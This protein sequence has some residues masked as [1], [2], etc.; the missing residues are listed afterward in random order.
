MEALSSLP[1]WVTDLEID[2]LLFSF[3][4]ASL[5]AG[6][7]VLR[8]AHQKRAM[9]LVLLAGAGDGEV[10]KR[11]TVEESTKRSVGRGAETGSGT[12]R[13]GH[14]LEVVHVLLLLHCG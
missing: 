12:L 4:E 5:E 1:S 2:G 6:F 10:R 7:E 8:M 14:R 3:L 9:D 11:A 13:L